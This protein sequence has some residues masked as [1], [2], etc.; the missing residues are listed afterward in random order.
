MIL[1]DPLPLRIPGLEY[2]EW[3]AYLR[4]ILQD[5]QSL[6]GASK[7]VI[8]NKLA[9]S[10]L[11][12]LHQN[13]FDEL[14][15]EAG[16]CFRLT[17]PICQRND[18][19]DAH[20]RAIEQIFKTQRQLRRSSRHRQLAPNSLTLEQS[21]KGASSALA[22]LLEHWVSLE[23]KCRAWILSDEDASWLDRLLRRLSSIRRAFKEA[24]E[25]N[26]WTEIFNR[27]LRRLFGA[28]NPAHSV[29]R[30]HTLNSVYLP[31]LI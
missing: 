5:L 10:V 22:S 12:D 31:L 18:Q 20:K 1:P 24:A 29:S 7:R 2:S 16:A 4:A 17:F 28:E 9:I 14:S 6:L 27:T 11:R 13:G 19:F 3:A 26:T 21:A 25:T 8:L 30:K 23:K 15:Y